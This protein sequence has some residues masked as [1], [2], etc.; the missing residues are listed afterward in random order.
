MKKNLLLLFILAISFASCTKKTTAKKAEKTENTYVKEHYTKKE[1]KITMRDGVKLHA[2]I[3]S[4]KDTSKTY[5]ILLQRTP[6]SCQPYGEDKFRRKIGPNPVLMKEGNI[7]VYQD[8]RGRWMSEGVYDNMRAYI[9]NKTAKQADETTDTYDTIDWL[10]NN[11]AN[12]NGKVGTWGISYPGHYATVSTI[13]AHPALK[14]ASPQACIGDFFFDDFHHNGAFLLSYFKAIS[15]FGT[16]KDQPTDSAWYSFP[17]MKTQDQ[18]QFFLDKGPLKNLT[19]YFQYDKLDTKVADN[20][21]RIDDFFWK[22]IVEHPNYDSVWQ[23]KGIIQH[24]DKVPSTVATMI[25]GGWFDAEDLYGPLE[26]YKN[27]EKNQPNNYN[28]VVFGPWD[29]GGWSR[30]KVA[31][32]VGNY[33]FGDSIS[34]KFQK[35]VETKFFN[36][37]LK[38]DGTKNSGLPEAYVFDTGKKAWKSYDVWPPKN[39]QKQT[40]F[41]SE[42]Q[43]LTATQKGNDKINFISNVKRPVPYS[44]DIKTVFT[45]RKYMTDDQRFAAR[46]PDVLV[47]ETEVL[48]EDFTLS[49]DILAKLQVATTGSAADWI[50]KVVDVHPADLKNDNKEMQP[51]LKLSNYHLMVRSEVM[52]GRFRNSFSNP[53]PFTP[54]KKTAVNIKLQDVF[55]TFKKGHKVQIQVQST[56][57][58]LIDLN[59]QTYV[60]NI[61]KADEKDFKTQT[62]SVFTDSSIEFTVLK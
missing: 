22:E 25:V 51:H 21:E 30:N 44:E 34:L 61:Y 32:K 4:P 5:P 14:A 38:G 55:H 23:S 12:N 6:Y 33:Y 62:H 35:E 26:T 9:P 7:I 42:N 29:H 54:N 31:N 57:F 43:E 27:I 53:E 47:F 50:V 3:Y 16:Y 1:V 59:P 37:F 2:T 39:A 41:L 46:R 15:L 8:V 60:D 11:V 20:K 17:D 45:P 13:D 58:P 49:G 24:L 48:T 10:V 36:H 56:W 52:R 19:E 18:Y 40:F 28:T